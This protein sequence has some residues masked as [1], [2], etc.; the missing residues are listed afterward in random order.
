MR[1]CLNRGESVGTT[2][3]GIPSAGVDVEATEASALERPSDEGPYSLLHA[4]LRRGRFAVT[5]E[6]GPP[7]SA[8]ARSRV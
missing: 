1:S 3:T 2:T 4:T 5:A 6:I 8:T 7:R